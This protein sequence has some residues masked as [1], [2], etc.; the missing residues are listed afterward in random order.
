MCVLLTCTACGN[1]IDVSAS[2]LY[3]ESY[4][5]MIH[6]SDLDNHSCSQDDKDGDDLSNRLPQMLEIYVMVHTYNVNETHGT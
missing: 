2:I 5:H 1:I 4:Y 6:T 3:L